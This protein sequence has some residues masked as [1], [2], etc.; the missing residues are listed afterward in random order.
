VTE[1]TQVADVCDHGV[2][3]GIVGWSYWQYKTYHDLT[4]SAGDRSEGFFNNDGTL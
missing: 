1:I 2:A 3:D 4:T